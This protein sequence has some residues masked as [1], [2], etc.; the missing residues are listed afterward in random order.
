A[1][2]F[3]EGTT[4]GKRMLSKKNNFSFSPELGL[5]L[6][7][8]ASVSLRY[9]YAGDTPRYNGLDFN[10]QAISLRSISINPI[11]IAWTYHILFPKQK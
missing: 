10:H 4:D 3:K 1:Y 5:R 6:T 8:T 7:P 9:L 2:I 11:L